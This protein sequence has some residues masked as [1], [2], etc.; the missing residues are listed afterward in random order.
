MV[1]GVAAMVMLTAGP[2]DAP[3][4]KLLALHCHRSPEVHVHRCAGHDVPV[5]FNPTG[6]V[7][8]P[9]NGGTGAC[10]NAT[11]KTVVQSIPH[12]QNADLVVTFHTWPRLRRRRLRRR[13]VRVDKTVGPVPT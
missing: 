10:K 4:V 12:T 1:A 6:P 11:G 13:A 8:V 5:T 3:T 7:T 2:A 9:I